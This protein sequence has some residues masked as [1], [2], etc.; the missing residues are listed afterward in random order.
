MHDHRV[1]YLDVGYRRSDF[2]HPSR[3]LVTERIG[4]LHTLRLMNLFEIT[5]LEVKI[6][7]AESRCTDHHDDVERPGGLRFVDI[8][9]MQVF[10]VVV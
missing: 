5:V 10:V 7:S 8:I 2:V 3:A 4:Q 6:G 1:T 9:D